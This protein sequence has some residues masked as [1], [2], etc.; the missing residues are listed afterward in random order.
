MAKNA[1]SNKAS[2]EVGMAGGAAAG[3]AAGALLGPVGAAIG[4]LV[5]GVAGSRSG[6]SLDGNKRERESEDRRTSETG[7]LKSRCP[8]QEWEKECSKVDF[9]ADSFGCDHTIY[10]IKVPEQSEGKKK[11]KTKK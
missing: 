2:Y 7:P 10:Q 3:A 11:S 1:P 9:H 4:A 5:G 8:C 6:I